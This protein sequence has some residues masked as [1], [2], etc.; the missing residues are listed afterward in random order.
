MA[1]CPSTAGLSTAP[2]DRRSAD[3]VRTAAGPPAALAT[4][5]RPPRPPWPTLATV[6]RRPWPPLRAQPVR[7]GARGCPLAHRLRRGGRPVPARDVRPRAATGVG[8]AAAGR[9][10]RGVWGTARGRPAGYQPF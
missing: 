4:V 6:S 2:A 10:R 8:C 9:P 5:S 3:R 1:I 7:A